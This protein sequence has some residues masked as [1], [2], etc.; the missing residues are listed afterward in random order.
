MA[1]SLIVFFGLYQGIINNQR[2]SRFVRYNGMQ[3]V[4][5]SIIQMCGPCKPALLQPTAG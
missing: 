3:A 4:L 5:L 2:F 1:C